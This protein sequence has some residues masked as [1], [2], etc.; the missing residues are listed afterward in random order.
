MHCDVT[1]G[2]W[3]LTSAIKG[4]PR[5][6][7]SSLP[8][9]VRA[10][11]VTWWEAGAG[12]GR[13][14]EPA[15]EAMDLLRTIAYQPGSTGASGGGSTTSS[16]KMGEQALGKT[17]SGESRRKKA[18][19][20]PAADPEHHHHHHHS[21]SS[22][23]VS[24]IITDPTTGRRYCRGKV[25]GKVNPQRAGSPGDCG[26][27]PSRAHFPGNKPPWMEW[28]LLLSRPAEDLLGLSLDY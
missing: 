28:G 21:H 18:V 1:I 17:C 10:A 8:V 6:L 24:R 2:G 7:P 26:C 3:G 12:L 9:I 20:A 19:T 16:S 14:E 22:T 13:W 27:H 23:E 5:S 15:D 11:P 25:L 4:E